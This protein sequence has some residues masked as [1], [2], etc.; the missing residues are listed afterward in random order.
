MQKIGLNTNG[1]THPVVFVII[2]VTVAGLIGFSGHR[3]WVKNNSAK[4]GSTATL[5][6]TPQANNDTPAP[7]VTLAKSV[8]VRKTGTAAAVAK[9]AGGSSSLPIAEQVQIAAKY[10]LKTPEGSLNQVINELKAGQFSNVLYFITPRFMFQSSKLMSASE[11]ATL[12]QC[13][14][15]SVCNML[16]N[17]EIATISTSLQY[18]YT[19]TSVS[20]EGK[21]LVFNLKWQDGKLIS[22]HPRYGGDYQ[23]T[24]DMLNI[25]ENWVIDRVTING[26]TI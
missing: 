20:A 2:I 16:L 4:Q 10:D 25:G 9:Q 5:K 21:S 3:V 22:Q 6:T 18:P 12:D 7:E 24:V 19:A 23:L 13:K 17:T 26:Y 11:P 1:F 14:S 15:N 8:A